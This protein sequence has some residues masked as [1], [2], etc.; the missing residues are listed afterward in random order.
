MFVI[1]F[2]PGPK[3]DQVFTANI[4]GHGHA[5]LLFLYLDRKNQPQWTEHFTNAQIFK[6]F[7]DASQPM[8]KL[9]ELAEKAFALMAKV[10]EQMENKP[11]IEGGIA[12]MPLAFGP[13][14]TVYHAEDD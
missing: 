14:A 1:I 3:T 4:N 6:T 11:K 2:R 5:P 9:D 13:V 8:C 12:I 10:F 7:F